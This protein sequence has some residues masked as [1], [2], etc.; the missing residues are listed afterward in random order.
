MKVPFVDLPLQYS[1]LKA[2][3]D[4]AVGAVMSK[5]NFVLGQE[6]FDFERDFASFVGTKHCVSVGSGT[7]AL[8]LILRGLGIGPGDEVITVTN[9]FIA[10][11]EAITYVGATPVLVDCL[12]GNYLI[13]PDAVAKKVTS[14]T[15]AV[16]P[17]HLYGQAA[18]I[19]PL[20]ELGKERGFAVVEDAAQAHGTTWKDGRRCGT[21]GVAAGFSFYPGKNL[22]AYG[23]G[24]AVTTNDDALADKLRLLRN[25]G[26]VVKYHH[27]IKGYNSRLDT[28]QAAVLGVKLKHLADWNASRSA[29]ARRYRER[30]SGV[31]GVILPEEAPWG[32]QHIYHLFVIRVPGKDRDEL[33]KALGDKGIQ[34][35]IHYPKPVHLQKAYA[36]LGLGMGAFPNAESVMDEI[37]SLPMFPEMTMEQADYVAETLKGLV[38]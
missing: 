33:M 27:D 3:I 2:E 7:D 13:D 36:D 32:G 35:G 37:F 30:L 24:G 28:M 9:T 8:Q 26:S 12:P 19:D 15:K 4:P 31:K 29:V 38:G 21:V 22:G 20:L 17:V 16:I 25:W 23:D 1:R 10:T 14:K 5:C 6:V 11:V 34:S 18:N